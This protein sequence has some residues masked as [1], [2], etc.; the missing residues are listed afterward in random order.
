M[1]RMVGGA[2]GQ[3]EDVKQADQGETE[4]QPVA[5]KISVLIFRLGPEWWAFRTQIIAE[6]TTPRPIHRVPHRTNEVFR[7]LVSLH[8][9][10]QICVSL[11]GLLGVAAP[12][13][14]VRLVVLRDRNWAENWAF[15]ADEVLG[16]Q[17]L[18]HDRWRGVPATLT[19]P[20]VGFSQGILSWNERSI[21]L[22][23]EDRVFNA[24]RSL[25]P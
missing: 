12:I 16:V 13:T 2:V 22:L 25:E 1:V 5:Q 14:A 19:N 10:V 24:L 11:H 18:S 3:N 8:G 7:G 6:V 23:D 15:V 17:H 4:R 20:A 9:Q 21:G